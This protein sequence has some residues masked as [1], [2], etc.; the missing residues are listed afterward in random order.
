MVRPAIDLEPYKDEILRRR[1]V[2]HSTDTI[3][4]WL[5]TTHNIDVSVNT[6]KRRFSEWSAELQRQATE[7]TED[8][9]TRIKELY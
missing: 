7:D 4:T 8:L 6:L 5:R 1:D 2:K 3:L 9:R